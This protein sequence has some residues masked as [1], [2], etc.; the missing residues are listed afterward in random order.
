MEHAVAQSGRQR[1]QEDTDAANDAALR[2]APAGQLT[3]T[4]EDIFKHRKLR[5][6]GREDH[7]QEEQRT[8]Q[9]AARHVEEHGGHG[10]EQQ[11]RTRAR[12]NI[13][14]KACRED[15]KAS[16]DR[17]EGVKNDDVHG[18]AQQGM[19]LADVA[20]ENGHGPDAD[21][22]GEERL[23]HGADYDLPVDLGEVG[24]QIEREALFR[25]VEHAAVES[26]HH[27]QHEKRHHHVLGHALKA[28]LQVKAQH[29]EAEGNGD[30]KV[31][32]VHGG[33]RDHVDEAEVCGA[34]DEE[35]H[36]VVHHPAGDDRVEGHQRD[37]AKQAQVTVDM[38]FL[39]WLFKLLV[40]LDRACL[41]SAAHGKFHSHGG[42]AEQ[43]QAQH[44]HQHETAA[45][46]LTR[47]P[48]EFPHVA[49]AD[50]T[51]RAEHDE[52]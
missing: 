12:G 49:A 32:H 5:G 50:G 31:D 37:V 41:G 44:V 36:E 39:A 8:P 9:A 38:P 48:R 21:G 52:T 23:I 29:T 26:Q 33:I 4:G 28:A 15:D 17:H 10:V 13:I 43:K 40:H 7:E 2:T 35:L 1:Q 46:I 3:H 18:L 27:H 45:A 11:R 14:G 30:G 42:Q 34:A 47:H 25:A 22:Q 51:A 24:H 19:I 6:E 16:H 20:A